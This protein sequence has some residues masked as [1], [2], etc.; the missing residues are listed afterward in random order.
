MKSARIT[1][2]LLAILLLIWLVNKSSANIRMRVV[3]AT[4]PALKVTD[5]VL[6][7]INPLTKSSNTKFTEKEKLEAKI[8]ILEARLAQMEELSLENERLREL[9]GFRKRISYDTIP[10][11]VI[12][13]DPSNWTNVVYIDKGEDA[14]IVLGMG[15]ATDS[16]IAGK[17]TEVSPSTSRAMLINDPDSRIAAVTQKSREQG[18]VCGALSRRCRMIYISP[19]A[20]VKIGELVVTSESGETFAGGLLIGKITDIFE[21]KGGL[22]RSAAIKPAADLR[23][24]EEVLCIK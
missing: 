15:I 4:Q 5:K 12:A 11:Q 16:G 18:L 3:A 17:V 10:A 6:H 1:T 19:D 13:R 7:K 24:L 21:D 9:V 23:K 2:I 8:K 14:G 22:F 20:D